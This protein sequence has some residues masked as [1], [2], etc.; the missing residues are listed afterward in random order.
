MRDI[1]VVFFKASQLTQ[2]KQG[3]LRFDTWETLADPFLE[4]RHVYQPPQV[5]EPLSD[6]EFA[7]S[8]KSHYDAMDEAMKNMVTWDYYLEQALKNRE[9]IEAQL[10]KPTKADTSQFPVMKQYAA[11]CC[12][13]L[14]N[15]LQLEALWQ[16]HGDAHQG[17]AVALDTTQDYFQNTHYAEQPQLFKPVSY[18][19]TRPAQPSR[20]DPFPAF[21][22]RAHHWQYE[23]ELR[24][25]RPKSAADKEDVLFKLPKGLMTGIYLGMHVPKSL[26]QAMREL[27]RL[28]LN[29]RHVPVFHMGVSQ[30]YLRL[31]PMP[32][33]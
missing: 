16:Q 19:D 30:E 14:F 10:Q 25:V 1:T 29:F 21:F 23:N 4:N 12:L 15:N 8:L 18:D 31:V 7:E 5:V 28:D 2:L 6:S 13:R 20:S 32:M 3:Y 11:V 27:I 24:L 33:E 17:F 22:Q 9:N 26:V